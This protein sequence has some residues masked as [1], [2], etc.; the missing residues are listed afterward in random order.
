MAHSVLQ[1]PVPALERAVPGAHV[2]LLGPF[3]DLADV[4]PALLGELTAL[5]AAT[6]P[7]GVRFAEV[8]EFPG[9]LAYLAPEPAARFLALTAALAARYPEHPPN[10]GEFDEVVPH[11]TV[12]AA[13]PALPVEVEATEAVLVWYDGPR[14]RTLARFPFGGGS[15]DP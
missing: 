5:F 1:V 11:L 13:R 9:G 14:T 7:F 10:G 4:T 3:V 8:R 15:A 12:Y 6:A 2:T